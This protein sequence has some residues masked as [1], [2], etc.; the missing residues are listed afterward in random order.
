MIE[1]QEGPAVLEDDLL[2]M[3]SAGNEAAIAELSRRGYTP[4]DW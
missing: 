2:V 1:D 4:T 3:A